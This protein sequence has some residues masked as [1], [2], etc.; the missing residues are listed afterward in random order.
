MSEE[1]IQSP[2]KEEYLTQLSVELHKPVRKKFKKRRVV[3]TSKDDTWA[4]DLVDMSMFHDTNDGIKWMMNVIDIYT[5][6]AWSVPMK[7]KTAKEVLDAF[8]K[9]MQDSDRKPS[10]IWVD[11][12]G[13]FY[14]KLWTPYLQQQGIVRYSTHGDSKSMMVER[15]NRTLKTE[16]WKRFTKQLSNRWIDM[17]PALMDW[18]NFKPHAGLGKQSPYAVSRWSDDYKLPEPECTQPIHP[19]FK[20]DDKVRISRWKG[21]FEKGYT[22][23]WSAEQFT[24]SGIWQSECGDPPHYILRDHF[25]NRIRAG[26]TKKSCSV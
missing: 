7:T 20:L 21:T 17:L 18:Y 14:N 9:I 22:A 1:I 8:Q 19:K 11:Q 10:K 2:T 12:G 13:E 25:H 23:N 4:M 3:L 24:V 5:R 15:F 16:M 6:F 26:S